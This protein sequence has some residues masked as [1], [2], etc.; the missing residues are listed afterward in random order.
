M[1]RLLFAIRCVR[2]VLRLLYLAFFL[3]VMAA[4][5]QLTIFSDTFENGVVSDSETCTNF[6]VSSTTTTVSSNV[7]SGGK[8]TMTV[9][10][11]TS[12]NG[13]LG[14]RLF[15]GPVKQDYN[16]FKR[17]LKF[18][19]DVTITGQYGL[20]R[21][22]LTGSA[23][24]TTVSNYTADDSLVVVIDPSNN[25]KLAVK[26]DRPLTVVENIT[27]LVNM[28]PG[29]TVTGFDLSLDATDYTFVIRFTGGAQSQTFSG[30][31]GLVASQW[32]T[33]GKTAF[34]F[35]TLRT[36]DS[37]TGAGI[38]VTAILDNF[39][40]TSYEPQ[41]SLF[42]DT[43]SNA[44]VADAD[45][46]T[47]MWST[48][49]SATGTIAE[50]GGQLVETVA[51]ATTNAYAV[52][53]AY[54][55]LQSRFNFFDHQVRL[56]ATM[57]QSASQAWLVSG[58]IGF[59][60]TATKSNTAPD[61]LIM[62]VEQLD[63][64][65]LLATRMDKPG[66]NTID[67]NGNTYPL[68]VS[69]LL[70]YVASST[71]YN[72]FEMIVNDKRFRLAGYHDNASL[73]IFRFSGLHGLDRSKW[74]TNGDSSLCLEATRNA[75]TG[76][77]I[78]TVTW[79]NVRVDNDNIRLL[80]EPSYAFTATYIDQYSRTITGSYRIWLP[81]TEPIIR[82]II[83]IGPGDGGDGRITTDNALW[84]ETARVLGFGLIG[85]S[86]NSRMNLTSGDNPTL[87]QTA[88]QTV[89]NAAASVTGRPE[90][91]NAPL[92]ATGNSRGA[93][94]SCYLARNWPKRV[95]TITPS[96]GGEWNSFTMTSD[97]QK[98]PV[99]F[100]PGSDDGNRMTWASLMQTMFS[101][102]RNQGG[103]V[104]YA[105][106]WN[107]GH[108]SAGNQGDEVKSLWIKE[109]VNQ[110]YPRPM[111][112]SLKPGVAPTLLSVDTSTAWLGDRATFN[113]SNVPVS[114]ST[115]VYVA[116]VASYSGTVANSSW[117]PSETMARAYRAMT[118]T[119]LVD[120]EA[121]PTQ[122]P[123]RIVSPA[124][125]AEFLRPVMVGNPVTIEIDPRDFDNANALASVDFYDGDTWLGAD[126]SGPTWQWQF[127]PTTAGAHSFSVVATDVLGNKRDA[128]RVL[129]VLPTDFPPQAR[130]LYFS[131]NPG[132]TKTGTLSGVDPEGNAITAYTVTT[133]PTHGSLTVNA[134]TG[135]Y[136]YIANSTYS[137]A[138]TF[139]YTVTDGVLTS[140]TATASIDVT[141]LQVG[142]ISTVTAAP[143]ATEG[144]ITL[145][146]SAATNAELY[147]IER[148]TSSNSGF[149][150][151]ATVN[152][153]ALTY[154]DA[155]LTM[156]QTYF[157]RAKAIYQ[158]T[159]SAYTTVVS[160]LPN[161]PY[162]TVGKTA[163]ITAA[164]GSNVGS[165]TLTWSATANA[166]AYRIDY[167]STTSGPFALI[168]NIAAPSVTAT[169]S[170][171]PVG[172]A[173]YFRVTPY[174][175]AYTGTS[176]DLA[177]A[178]PFFPSTIEGWCYTNFGSTTVPGMT[179]D[180]DTPYDQTTNLMRYALGF[181]Y[182]N[183]S[184]DFIA[185]RSTDMPYVQ[186]Q[187][188]SGSRYLTC[189]FIH[190]KNASDLTVKVQVA[191]EPGGPWTDIDPFQAA[192]QVGVMD[193]VPAT[194][195]ETI[196]VKDS[197]PISSS[198]KRFMRIR[199]SR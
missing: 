195:Q 96:C 28:N 33:D 75:T 63:S 107:V 36:S 58:R 24:G 91:A 47:A 87:I 199:V 132:A 135:A 77:E 85:Y 127:T 12:G 9:G 155:N 112:P 125:Y 109:I 94:D 14:A 29:S 10:G 106:N 67:S 52:G 160:S 163:S 8:M 62:E 42:E 162:N 104:A 70:G 172:A 1:K 100:M 92:C 144:K 101:W 65:L 148:S 191:A 98:I 115:L 99:L 105:V 83:F 7:E 30:K 168:G 69:G 133:L 11:A 181:D 197:Q 124:Q 151:I 84:Q 161:N 166:T 187:S 177:L 175:P 64:R 17:K 73:G 41:Q 164:T 60:S 34:Q 44:T 4:N 171:L 49:P 72:N 103:L 134:A 179:G 193:N 126:S 68:G 170:N 142:T 53:S 6:W 130:S 19:S 54:T 169:L 159:E 176:S 146:W 108:T 21:F 80:D 138:D 131:L 121:V 2:P 95:V 37:S 186:E 190:N 129:Y 38:T 123:V 40:V 89:L 182:F 111:A 102:W 90:I 120:R 198:A 118:S 116:P 74:G 143:G 71:Q 149:A 110:R 145:T 81:S 50:T 184:G 157:Y 59:T 174:N 141:G 20:F 31:H 97:I 39:S 180:L 114:T 119:D 45:W 88:V 51:T 137:G 196:I 178:T 23:S 113:S 165:V 22:A 55:T 32:G 147:K 167:A 189:T 117:L 3:G 188:I 183:G 5:A 48:V 35:E 57:T 139:T 156:T 93:F 150:Q 26:Q 13:S 16:F 79:D 78:S 46:D 185:L 128:F 56:S 27:K 76:Q 140:T 152:A 153:P 136:T 25:V 122:S 194:G 43:F 173:L 86:D 15:S 154:T 158:G 66:Y 82:G 61:V 192:N 18:S